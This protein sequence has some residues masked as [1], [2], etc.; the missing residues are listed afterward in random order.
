MD[1]TS[2]Y[3]DC[4]C[5]LSA[6]EFDHDRDQVIQKAK[7]NRVSAIVVVTEF[8]EDFKKTLDLCLEN[9]LFLFPCIGIH[10]VQEVKGSEFSR[11]SKPEDLQEFKSI[12][13]SNLDSLVGIGEVGLDFTPRYI[14][15]PA[16]KENQRQ[17]L[18]EQVRIA[19]EFNLPVNV[20]SRSAGR[21]TIQLLAEENTNSAVLHAFDGRPSHALQGVKHGYYFSVPPCVVRSEQTQ[22][23]AKALPIESIV[24]ETDSP[25]LGPEKTS[26][27]EP[28]NVQL[29]CEFIAKIKNMSAEHVKQITSENALK[30]FPKLKNM[31]KYD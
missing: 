6:T 15:S 13:E 3:I 31:R 27:N 25:A 23:L 16:D 2:G 18:R 11:S 30:L 29:S 14:K 4:H 10:P 1:F 17:V 8:K 12:V 7:K 21:P 26:R 20:H 24:L 9:K 5:H 28:S 22:K 19:N